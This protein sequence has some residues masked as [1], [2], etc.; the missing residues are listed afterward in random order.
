MAPCKILVQKVGISMIAMASFKPSVA[1]NRASDTEGSPRPM[2]P[3]TEPARMKVPVMIKI[4]SND[5]MFF[6]GVFNDPDG[7]GA[8]VPSALVF[9]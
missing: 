5:H 7:R 6:L 2:T 3:L 1:V 8:I 9:V 4:V